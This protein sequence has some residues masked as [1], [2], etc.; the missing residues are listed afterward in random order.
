MSCCPSELD[1]LLIPVNIKNLTFKQQAEYVITPEA[2]PLRAAVHELYSAMIKA[3][4]NINRGSCA[5]PYRV[6]WNSVGGKF[7]INGKSL[8]A[9]YCHYLGIG[10]GFAKLLRIMLEYTERQRYICQMKKN[11]KWCRP[12]N[13]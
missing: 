2:L 1:K 9:Y 13:N 10:S 4:Y 7:I 5:N 3:N 8:A 11:G 12:G 6:T